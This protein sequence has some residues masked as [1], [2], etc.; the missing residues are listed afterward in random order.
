MFDSVMR[1]VDLTGT[2]FTLL[3]AIGSAQ[4]DSISELGDRLYIEKSTLSRNLR[5]L[6]KAGLIERDISK[7]GRA[8]SLVLTP[9]GHQRLLKAYPLWQD[10][11]A[12]IE[13]T[14]GSNMLGSG[15]EFLSHL[16]K[17]AKAA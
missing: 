9:S 1:E 15:F 6:E 4:F 3:V 11:Q 5:P 10:M 8:I 7:P 17:A 12:N 14:L 13:N 16:R 2:Q